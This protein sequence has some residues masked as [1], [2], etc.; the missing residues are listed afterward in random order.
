MSFRDTTGVKGPW[1]PFSLESAQLILPPNFRLCPNFR[2]LGCPRDAPGMPPE[3][4][5]RIL[6]PM[7]TFS[8]HWEALL[9][10]KGR[11]GWNV[12]KNTWSLEVE[13]KIHGH[14][15]CCLRQAAI[16]QNTA[17]LIQL[18]RSAEGEI[19][20]LPTVAWKW[21]GSGEW[22]RDSVNT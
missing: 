6:N 20:R 7:Q 1:A 4:S 16:C 19:Y 21:A 15:C 17:V 5:W 11:A 18:Q 12:I 22:R 3:G 13:R 2:S 10:G 8:E 9:L 14:V